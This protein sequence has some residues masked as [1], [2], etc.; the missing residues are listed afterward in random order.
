MD[1]KKKYLKYKKKYQDFKIFGGAESYIRDYVKEDILQLEEN[2]RNYETNIEYKNINRKKYITGLDY[3]K[4]KVFRHEYIK[5]IGLH[6]EDIEQITKID[7]IQKEFD[8]CKNNYWLEFVRQA[9]FVEYLYNSSMRKDKFFIFPEVNDDINTVFSNDNIAP[10]Y[11]EHRGRLRPQIFYDF[12]NHFLALSFK[13]LMMLDYDKKDYVNPESAETEIIKK[14]ENLQLQF[15]FLLFRTDR[16]IHIFIINKP[17]EYNSLD[18]VDIMRAFCADPFYTAFSYKCGYCIRTNPKE[19]YLDD[20][21]A[22]FGSAFLKNPPIQDGEHLP[23][24]SKNVLFREDKA[25][26]EGTLDE[27]I[28]SVLKSFTINSNFFEEDIQLFY[29]KKSDIDEDGTVN[30]KLVFI[31]CKDNIDNDLFFNVLQQYIFI[32]FFKKIKRNS[33][34]DD[35]D[36]VYLFENGVSDQLFNIANKDNKIN[37]LRNDI[38]TIFKKLDNLYEVIIR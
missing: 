20:N 23:L 22:F 30:N 31:G 25:F 29:F 33:N 19:Q 14:L 27:S 1:Y 4:S 32:Q 3:I 21:V 2:I 36:Y 26:I 24:I 13:N 28:L 8:N 37:H 12:R 10:D 6:I 38:D 18:S 16:G 34:P 9:S 5:H 17:Y 15:S 11:V 35:I 7:A